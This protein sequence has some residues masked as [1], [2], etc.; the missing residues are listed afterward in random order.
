MRPVVV[1]LLLI[2]VVTAQQHAA[3]QAKFEKLVTTFLSPN[4]DK[5]CISISEHVRMMTDGWMDKIAILL[6]KRF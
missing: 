2:A 6:L 5:V 1:L 3:F 4:T